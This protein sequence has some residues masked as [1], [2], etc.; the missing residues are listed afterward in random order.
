MKDH[1]KAFGFLTLT[2]KPLQC[3]VLYLFTEFMKFCLKINKTKENFFFVYIHLFL[4]FFFPLENNST[5]NTFY[6]VL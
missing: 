5:N 4:I 6:F 2:K 3:L 1:L